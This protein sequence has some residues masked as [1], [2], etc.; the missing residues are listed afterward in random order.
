MP[1]KE[2]TEKTH[3][4]VDNCV[5]SMMTEWFCNEKRGL[6]CAALLEQ[7]H[8][9]L[10][11][12]I[13]LFQRFAV[14][15][16][17]HTSTAVSAEYKPWHDSCG[18]RKRGV[19]IP[20][21]QTMAKSVCAR[22]STHEVQPHHI[23]A[24]KTL[25][26]VS[27]NLVKK[28]TNQDL[29]LVHVGLCLS[30]SGNQVYILTN[31]QDLLQYISWAHA[32]K[33]LRNENMNSQLVEGLSGITFLDLVHRGCYISSEQLLKM[34]GYVI[35]DTNERMFRADPMA[36]GKEKGNKIITDTTKMLGTALLES[37]TLKLEKQGRGAAA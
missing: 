24:L 14:D 8:N 36:L 23:D 30:S 19:E 3:L 26:A 7:T 21:I 33:C 32:Q 5:L 35:S 9:W 13:N 18:L 31:D 6:P 34:I 1:V 11:E 12:Q 20:K 15:G 16:I 22:F 10:Q 27:P 37:M 17:L 2:I 25:P 29:S 4:V 28:L